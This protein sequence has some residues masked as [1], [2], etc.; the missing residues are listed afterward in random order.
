MSGTKDGFK[1]RL[2]RL[3]DAA[4]I[5]DVH[6]SHVPRWYRQIGNEQHEVSYGDLTLDERFGFGGPWMSQET[7]AIHLN[8][9]LL[10]RQMPLVAEENGRVVGEMELFVGREGPSYGKNCHIGLLYVHKEAQDRGIGRMMVER[11]V[12][13]AEENRCD[14]ITV[15]SVQTCEEFY[16]KCGFSF[17]DTQVEI[18]AMSGEYLVG[19]AA[20]PV[21]VSVQA[22]CWGLDMNVGRLQSSA[23]HVFEMADVYALPSEAECVRVNAFFDVN[24]HR[25][26]LSYVCLPSGEVEVSAWSDGAEAGDLVFAVLTD[27]DDRG[28]RSANMLIPR[29][30]YGRIAGLVDVRLIGY[31]H[32]LMMKL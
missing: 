15:A 3:D 31:R 24:G 28:L 14:T 12:R 20:L 8:N 9:L 6:L 17:H 22:F 10:H 25:S 21:P 23:Y 19:M 26:L 13:H 4:A 29:E 27:L 32:T 1:V 16:R 30:D 18:E 2:A 5:V 11:A 7:C